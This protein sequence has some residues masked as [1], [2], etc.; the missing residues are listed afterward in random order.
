MSV[1]PV[2]ATTNNNEQIVMPKNP[3]KEDITTRQEWE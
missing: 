1:S 3:Q 2:P